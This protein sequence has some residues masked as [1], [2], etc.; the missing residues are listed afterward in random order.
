MIDR[1]NTVVLE[2]G[3]PAHKHHDQQRVYSLYGV[4]SFLTGLGIRLI[5]M[6]LN[7]VGCG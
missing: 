6:Q 4:Q 7:L 5:L 1:P 2:D 3:A